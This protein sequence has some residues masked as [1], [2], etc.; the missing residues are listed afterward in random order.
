MI[1]NVFIYFILIITVIYTKAL[2]Q[3]AQEA[4]DEWALVDIEMAKEKEKSLH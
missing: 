3:E 2:A 1:G 4:V